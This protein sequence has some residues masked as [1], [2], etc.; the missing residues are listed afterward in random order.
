MCIS[1]DDAA[2]CNRTNQI[3]IH[4]LTS[5]LKRK[6]TVDKKMKKIKVSTTLK[7]SPTAGSDSH[8]E[9]AG[10]DVLFW[11]NRSGF[12]IS[13]NVWDR[14]FDHAAKIHPAGG[15]VVREL[16]NNKNHPPVSLYTYT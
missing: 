10:D 8:D 16:K 4:I 15:S 1:Y 5:Y 14:M 9:S 7:P 6:Q 2:R 11:I 13:D 12:P 3:L